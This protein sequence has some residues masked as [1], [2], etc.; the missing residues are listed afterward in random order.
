MREGERKGGL[1]DYYP[2]LLTFALSVS[3]VGKVAAIVSWTDSPLTIPPLTWKVQHIIG[4]LD[5]ST[6]VLT[7]MQ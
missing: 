6:K 7:N 4:V 3:G 5:N 2:V 1:K